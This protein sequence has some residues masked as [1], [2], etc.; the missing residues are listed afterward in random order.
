M[1][2][3]KIP[4]QDQ[5]QNSNDVNASGFVFKTYQ[6]GT[7]T[8]TPMAIDQNG[9]TTVA[10]VTLNADGIPEVSGNEVVLYID[11]NFRFA[12]YENATD[13]AADTNAFYGPV[14]VYNVPGL[15]DNFSQTVVFSKGDDVP[16]AATLT[17]GNDG[18]YF[19]VTG[20]TTITSIATVG[21]GAQ[22]KLH[23]D[24]VLTLTHNATDL[25]LPGGA[26]ITT[27]AGDEA[28]FVEYATGDWRCVNYEKADGKPI[29]AENT[30]SQTVSF[31]K[32]ANIASATALTLGTDGNYFD[33]TGTT[34]IN[35]INSVSIGTVIKLHFDDVL[36]LT[37]NATDLILPGGANITTAAGDEAEFVEYATG[38][39][40]CTYYQRANGLPVES[41]E[42]SNITALTG[43]S[44]DITGI[45]S[46]ADEVI[47]VLDQ[48][49]M[50]GAAQTYIQLGTG[51][52]PTTTGYDTY[53]SRV[54]GSSVSSGPVTSAFSFNRG[55]GA[56]DVSGHLRF[57]RI[58]GNVWVGSGSGGGSGTINFFC[59]GRISLSGALDMVRITSSNGT[60]TFDN[61]NARVYWR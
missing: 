33:V 58:T 6:V 35:S 23:F 28:E 19:D 13:A 56:G 41:V 1:A 60:D 43:T 26:N 48:S 45:P 46:Y 7:T 14:D 32:G 55:S 18:N 61:G 53:S 37:H 21:V 25:I 57:T 47:V 54:G 52:V 8:P 38:D 4:I 51:G 5:W 30:F 34:T 27:A 42:S 12:I 29:L 10:T 15:S 39:W 20:T 11:Q 22:I 44:V 31:A 9:A 36:T 59:N 2:W 40:R 24:D 49:S 50:S 17:L 3:V 16:S